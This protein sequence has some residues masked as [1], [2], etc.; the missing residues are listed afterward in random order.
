MISSPYV[1]KHGLL[2]AKL[3]DIVAENA[4]LWSVQYLLLEHDPELFDAL[5]SYIH[6]CKTDI[7]GLY[8]QFPVLHGNK[9]DYMS[10][11]QLIA[12]LAA[13]KMAKLENHIQSIWKYLKNNLA[14]Y[15]NLTG[16]INFDRTMQVGA[17]AFAGACAGNKLA[18]FVLSV[19]CIYSCATKRHETSGKLKAWTMFKALDMNIT[20][21]ICTYFIAKTPFKNWKGIFL[22]YFQEKEHPT[23]KLLE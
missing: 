17:L 13:F 16:K 4:P 2:N 9:D 23:R 6:N 18:K 3:K 15:D 8:N 19:A 21:S 7:D 5:I 12:F 11:D 1:N 14:T 10:P 20:E 22:E